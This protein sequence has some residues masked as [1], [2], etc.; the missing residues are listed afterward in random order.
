[1]PYGISRQI[2]YYTGEHMVEIQ[3]GGI[4]YA[5]PDMLV[6][7]YGYGE[8]REFDRPQAAALE[9]IKIM[10]AWQVDEEEK[11]HL[12]VRGQL[13][14]EWG[15]EGD[16]MTIGEVAKWAREEW[17]VLPKCEHC[18]EVLPGEN[19]RYGHEYTMYDNEYPFCSKNCA[20]NNYLDYVRME[21]EE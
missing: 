2:Y 18:G 17:R 7:H 6:P 15:C 10:K 19:Q 11:I 14:G 1:M 20:E 5:G 3:E 4:D 9:A 8:G 13:A 21:E 16:P 12:T